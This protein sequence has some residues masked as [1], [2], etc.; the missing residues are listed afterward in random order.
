MK[1]NNLWKI[2]K[3]TFL[4]VMKSKYNSEFP[5]KKYSSFCVC[6]CTQTF[7]CIE[8]VFD[9]RQQLIKT[10]IAANRIGR[11]MK[12]TMTTNGEHGAK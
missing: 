4:P 12:M 3:K 6:V 10:K 1:R 11:R 7:F 5:T 9:T 2:K 8:N